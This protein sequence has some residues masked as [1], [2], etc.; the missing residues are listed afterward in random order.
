MKH[1][2]HYAVELGLKGFKI[3]PFVILPLF[4]PNRYLSDCRLNFLD[5]VAAQIFLQP[6]FSYCREILPANILF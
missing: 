6:K 3:I 4:G 5:F 1:M 2:N